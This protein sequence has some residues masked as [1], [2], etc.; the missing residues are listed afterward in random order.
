MPPLDEYLSAMPDRVVA[1]VNELTTT[2]LDVFGMLLF[3]AAAGVAG[4]ALAGLWLGLLGA[5]L[6]VTVLSAFA[7][8]R[9]R[10]RPIPDEAEP[11]EPQPLPGAEHP[12]NLHVLGR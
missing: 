9:S 2:F 5:G 12:G 10:P 6:T 1:R 11:I 3:T 7:Q 8:W 4:N